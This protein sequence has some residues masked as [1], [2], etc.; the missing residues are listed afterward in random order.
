MAREILI[1]ATPP[2]KA[3]E[4]VRREWVRLILP[5][6]DLPDGSFFAYDCLTEIDSGCCIA[7]NLPGYR[8]NVPK[9]AAIEALKIVNP[10]AAQ[11]FMDNLYEPDE[12]HW[13]VFPEHVCQL[14]SE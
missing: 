10:A 13:I 9:D 14:I 2:G 12:V 8:Y 5:V 3:P 7:R 4:W 6:V 1:F 11:C